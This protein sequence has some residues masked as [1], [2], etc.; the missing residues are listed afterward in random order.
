MEDKKEN[1]LCNKSYCVEIEMVTRCYVMGGIVKMLINP[2]KLRR[3]VRSH[4]C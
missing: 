1:V 4:S 3:I 2:R